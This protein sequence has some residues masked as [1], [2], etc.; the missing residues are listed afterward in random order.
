MRPAFSQAERGALLPSVPPELLKD[1]DTAG[2]VRVRIGDK[3]EG[4]GPERHDAGRKLWDKYP[5]EYGDGMYTRGEFIRIGA[6]D[7]LAFLQQVKSRAGR[8]TARHYY[9]K[10]RYFVLALP[11]KAAPK[12]Q[13]EPPPR[14]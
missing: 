13:E 6:K 9:F 10:S 5:V 11:A 8:L 12:R 14:P 4:F 1:I 3:Q 7:L 2:S